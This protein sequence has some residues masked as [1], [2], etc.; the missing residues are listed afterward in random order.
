MKNYHLT[1]EGMGC[2][3]CVK[4]VT[5]AL[6]ELGADVK[7]CTIGEAD[8]LYD[9]SLDAVREAVDERGFSIASITEE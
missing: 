8:I 2:A 6:T 4:S 7:S 9:G 1:I 3:H 5:Q